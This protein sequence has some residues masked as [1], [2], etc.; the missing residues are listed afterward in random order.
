MF[1]VCVI[2]EIVSYYYS[3][4]VTLQNRP[5]LLR[6]TFWGNLFTFLGLILG[7][8]FWRMVSRNSSVLAL[9]FDDFIIVFV[10]V[11]KMSSWLLFNF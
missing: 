8:A 6:T 4:V 3:V 1:S 10:G 2:I 9:L 11:I 7:A 5:C